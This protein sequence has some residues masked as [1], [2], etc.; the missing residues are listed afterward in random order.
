MVADLSHSMFAVESRYTGRPHYN[1]N[2]LKVLVVDDCRFMCELLDCILKSFGIDHLKYAGDGTEA[3][4]ILGHFRPDIVICDWEMAP[5]N[6]PEFVRR[7]RHESD[8]EN[9]FAHVIMLTA[10]SEKQRVMHARDIGVTEFLTKPVTAR[11]L[12]SRLNS[13][14][15]NPRPF[16]ECPTYHGPDRRRVRS[17]AYNGVEKRHH[18]AVAV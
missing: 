12:F 7:L 6:G 2:R 11:D 9:R 5:Q 10:Y 17:I 8:D 13:I 4:P 3:W 16:I 1:L 15:E 18:D 14:I